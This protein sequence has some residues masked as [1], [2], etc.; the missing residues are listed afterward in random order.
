MKDGK[1]E[2]VP[3]RAAADRGGPLAEPRFVVVHYTGGTRFEGAEST[4]TAKDDRYVSAHLLIGRDGAREQLV[5]LDRVAYHAGRSRWRGLD[6]LNAYSIGIELVNPGWKAPGLPAWETVRAQQSQGGPV[7]DWYTYPEVQL[8]A[9]EEVLTVLWAELP[10][11]E[12]VI[13]HEHIAP[14]RKFD[15]GPA[16]P[17]ERIR[18]R[19]P[20]RV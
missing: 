1:I 4:L 19:F 2:G 13:G 8:L 9:L 18:A 14:G 5:R 16:F 17:W 15:P 20:R 3:F 6:G 10:S 12:E 11:L 7:R